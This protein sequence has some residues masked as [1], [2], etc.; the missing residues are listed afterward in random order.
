LTRER[1]FINMHRSCRSQS[2]SK[3]ALTRNQLSFDMDDLRA[4]FA[5]P[6]FDKIVVALLVLMDTPYLLSNIYR[7]PSV[8]LFLDDIS[9]ILYLNS[10]NFILIVPSFPN[11][12]EIKNKERCEW[13]YKIV[14]EWVRISLSNLSNL[15]LNNL[16]FIFNLFGNKRNMQILL[17]LE[18]SEDEMT[19]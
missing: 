18:N 14:T 6:C 13:I 9:L 19:N 17:N 7:Y 10:F 16:N 12:I 8:T 1:R 4:I 15:K 11:M 5:P 3:L 2:L